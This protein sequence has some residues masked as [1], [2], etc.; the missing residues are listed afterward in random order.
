MLG[1]GKWNCRCCCCCWQGCLPSLASDFFFFFL[2]IF[3]FFLAIT[4]IALSYCC[5]W[6][7]CLRSRYNQL[8]G[9]SGGDQAF[10]NNPHLECL[11]LSHNK[12][13]GLPAEVTLCLFHVVLTLKTQSEYQWSA[14]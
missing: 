11:L 10:E 1:G 8:E 12:L 5:A 4:I 9:L 7:A 2:F 14:K 3:F 6:C 13:E